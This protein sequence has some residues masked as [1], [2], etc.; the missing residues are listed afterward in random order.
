MKTNSLKIN[1]K[2]FCVVTSSRAEFGIMRNLLKYL[3]KNKFVDLKI[4]VTGS[5][6]SKKY[7]FTVK[8]ITSNNFKIYK[9]IPINQKNNTANDI[10]KSS[11]LIL[12]KLSKSL[13]I[14]KPDL[15]ILLGDRYEILIAAFVATLLKIPIAHIS[16]GE[17]TEGSYDNQFRHSVSKMSTLHFV[18]NKIYKNRLVQMGEYPNKVFNFGSLSLDNLKNDIFLSKKEIEKKFKI[19][20]KKT[21]FLI[22]F[23]PET[24]GKRNL[25]N[26]FNEILTSISKFKNY[27]FIFTASN[28]DE[29]G[30]IINEMIK[31]YVHKNK[32]AFFVKSFGQKYYFSI[33]NTIDG[34]IGN[35]SSG[36]IE[37]PSFKI[38][39]INIGKRQEG[40]IKCKSII[41][42]TA[43]YKDITRSIKRAV[44]IKFVKKISK[45][46]NPYEKKNTTK[47]ISKIL[48]AYKFNQDLKKKFYEKKRI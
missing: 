34:V 26:D 2:I 36:I 23:H 3:K 16:G 46:K 32:N 30:N 6:L 20:F 27:N 35:S 7:G 15:L 48:C 5:H 45:I 41:D 18:S 11:S 12:K 4:V 8:E 9:K 47:K 24:L 28:S 42:C 10:S 39:T 29:E 13:S 37:V 17:L 38:G 40:R 19:K 14:L 44:S 31:E 22:T 25:R 33:L 21:N 43:T 1:K